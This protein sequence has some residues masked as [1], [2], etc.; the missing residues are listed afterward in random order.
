MKQSTA[1][2]ILE[3]GNNVV[4]TGAPGAGKTYTI[5]QFLKWCFEH[6]KIAKVTATTGV[7]TQQFEN[8][9]TIDSFA[10]II[11]GIKYSPYNLSS[12][13]KEQ[14]KLYDVL[15]IDEISMLTAEKL[16]DVDQFLRW[17]RSEEADENG[18]PILSSKSFGGIQII[19]CGDLFQLPPVG[20]D[21][22]GNQL[23][24]GDFI[25]AEAFGKTQFVSCYLTGQHRSDDGELINILSA[26]R[27]NQITAQ[28]KSVLEAKKV[29]K[30]Q[31]P[32]VLH[33]YTTNDNAN[34]EN[35]R[36]LDELNGE[37]KTFEAIKLGET[38]EALE[39]LIKSFSGEMIL[40]LKVGA[41]VM[42]IRNDLDKR[43]VNGSVGEVVRFSEAGNPV[44][45]F[46][47]Y[48][49]EIEIYP[50]DFDLYE[51]VIIDGKRDKKTIASINQCPLKLG[52]AITVHKS[53]GMTLDEAYIDLTKCFTPGQGYVALSRLRNLDGLHLAGISGTAYNISS[54]ALAV[55]ELIQNWSEKAEAQV[56][57]AG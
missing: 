33:L 48:P 29:D 51:E 6:D 47:R 27:K 16:D 8:A 56:L 20:K 26:M 10:H 57:H 37:E 4:L 2:K 35:L 5:N 32:D 23:Q 9:E 52:W 19:L 36:R 30:F 18:K 54:E 38:D 21:K 46:N 53:Q 13:A 42:S 43:Y 50:A 12:T 40:G 22:L 24:V 3:G 1:L 41:K 45:K 28:M 44:V 31:V 15:I 14:I 17:A 49:D 39:R 11:P 25:H 7:A 34:E 55:D